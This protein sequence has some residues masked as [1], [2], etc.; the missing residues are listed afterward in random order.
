MLHNIYV[1][2]GDEYDD[3]LVLP[4]KEFM[5]RQAMGIYGEDRFKQRNPVW[6]SDYGRLSV[7]TIP[8]TMSEKEYNYPIPRLCTDM[9][10]APYAN[11]QKML[12]VN[13]GNER[14]NTNTFEKDGADE[15]VYNWNYGDA[16]YPDE[17]HYQQYT[18][19][20]FATD[21]SSDNQNLNNGYS[22]NGNSRYMFTAA[23]LDG[24]A[25]ING[26]AFVKDI[27]E[28]MKKWGSDYDKWVETLTKEEEVAFE[29]LTEV[30]QDVAGELVARAPSPHFRIGGA[31]VL[32]G[33]S[34]YQSAKAVE[35]EWYK[36]VRQKMKDDS[37]S[38]KEAEKR[39]IPW[40]ITL[41]CLEV[42]SRKR[43]SWLEDLLKEIETPISARIV[44]M[45]DW[46]K[47]IK[48]LTGSEPGVEATY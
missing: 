11:A 18:D 6:D 25:L 42:A 8:N 32:V 24:D 43:K 37:C 28:V 22:E 21:W 20:S 36:H 16:S 30:A 35:E 45:Q 12:Y 17:R 39:S 26:P 47:V 38:Q 29:L 3:G 15:A 33:L 41:I 23:A 14:Y 9:K 44:I 10:K 2:I 7:D 34:I 5:N 31:V 27:S 19:D 13:K 48:D 40:L 1:I 46:G 4:R